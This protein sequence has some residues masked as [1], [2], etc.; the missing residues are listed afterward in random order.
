[1]KTVKPVVFVH[2]LQVQILKEENIS[3][4]LLT[5]QHHTLSWQHHQVVM[6]TLVY[7]HGNIIVHWIALSGEKKYM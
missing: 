7:C 5:W 4:L 6:A 2:Q 1:M 3:G